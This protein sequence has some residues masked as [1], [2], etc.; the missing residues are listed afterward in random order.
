MIY[1]ETPQSKHQSSDTKG[2]LAGWKGKKQR[3]CDEVAGAKE[4]PREVAG[5]GGAVGGA[6]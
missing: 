6:R 5:Q 2:S 1:T 4:E 3:S